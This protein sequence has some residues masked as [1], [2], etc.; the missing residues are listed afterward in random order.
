MVTI[1]ISNR[2]MYSLLA[3][4]LIVAAAGIAYASTYVGA[5]G[6]GHDRN[7]VDFNK[8]CRWENG[9]WV[10]CPVVYNG[11][12]RYQYD[13][14][15]YTYSNCKSTCNGTFV[16]LPETSPTPSC[17]NY[18]DHTTQTYSSCPSGK[19]YCGY[20]GYDPR[21][22]HCALKTTPNA[23]IATYEF[24]FVTDLN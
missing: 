22:Y 17:V 8:V 16:T 3:V 11:N 1:N 4:I 21:T 7:E 20:T 15:G 6:V 18:I 13:V 23:T 19:T 5:N 10:D 12:I 2:A 9:A 24:D 14:V